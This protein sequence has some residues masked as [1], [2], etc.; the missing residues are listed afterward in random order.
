MKILRYALATVIGLF[1]LGM[2]AFFFMGMQSTSGSAPGLVDGRLTDCPSSPNCVSSEAGTA[3]DQAVAALPAEA[4]SQ[5][6]ALIAEMGGEVT[7]EEATYLSAEFTSSLFRFVDDIEFRLTETGIM[8]RSASRVGYS[9]A[10]V[11]SARVEE[12]RAKLASN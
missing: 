5:L 3:E 2:I 11:N 9:D 12:I 4:W 1:V 7:S 10:G 8:V 6:P